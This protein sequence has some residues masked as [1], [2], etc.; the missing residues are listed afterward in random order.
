[1]G[2]LNISDKQSFQEIENNEEL[3]AFFKKIT[4]HYNIICEAKEKEYI[5]QIEETKPNFAEVD[6]L[7][8]N[9]K[10]T[11]IKIEKISDYKN[12]L[13]DDLKYRYESLQ[14]LILLTFN[15]VKL[16]ED[17]VLYIIDHPTDID[18][19]VNYLNSIC[20]SLKQENKDIKKK[21]SK[22]EKKEYNSLN[23]VF[24][25]MKNDKNL[26]T[27]KSK[28]TSIETLEA[29]IHFLE[30][31]TLEQLKLLSD[32]FDISRDFFISYQS[33]SRRKKNFLTFLKKDAKKNI[34]EAYEEILNNSLATIDV[35]SIIKKL[36]KILL[37]SELRE[38]KE[39]YVEPEETEEEEETEVPEINRKIV[40]WFINENS[41]KIVEL[42]NIAFND[43]EEISE[44]LNQKVLKKQI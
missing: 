8:E 33:Y 38:L 2:L 10:K 42:F 20:N 27:L 34:K 21:I 14:P 13:K 29:K 5:I 26:E 11:G 35:D 30:N 43:V 24:N 7:I 25:Q 41:D 6:L 4:N 36:F 22:L 39:E 15:G 44:S 40:N 32:F 28:L 17:D 1:M 3:N 23:S 12:R 16:T 9:I 19:Q 18:L 37:K 31:L